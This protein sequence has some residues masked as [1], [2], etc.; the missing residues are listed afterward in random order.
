MSA[1]SASG[2]VGHRAAV[3]TFTFVIA[4]V[5]RLTLP[6]GMAMIGNRSSWMTTVALTL[7]G[8]TA[9]A[10]AQQISEARIQELIRQ[11]AANVANAQAGQTAPA[12]SAAPARPTTRLTL[13]DA[14][15]SALD[16]NLDI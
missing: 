4:Q 12:Q 5:S 2:K 7:V 14:V 1:N 6:K 10:Y 8:V 9:P 3:D 16:R 15:K 11:A 13:E